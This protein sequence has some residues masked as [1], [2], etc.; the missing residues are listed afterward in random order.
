[1]GDKHL[2]VMQDFI[3]TYAT[4]LHQLEEALQESMSDAGDILRDPVALSLSSYEQTNI[5][6]LI[7]TENKV[8]NKVL[9]VFAALCKE[10]NQLTKLVK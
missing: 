10:T 9:L 6:E 8:F 1:M 3:K 2:E 7:N 5:I 4:Q